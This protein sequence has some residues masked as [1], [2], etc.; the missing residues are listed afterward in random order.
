MWIMGQR[1]DEKR[2]DT[3]F[4]LTPQQMKDHWNIFLPAYIGTKDPQEIAAYTKRLIPFYATKV[5]YVYDMA[6]HGSLPETS[7]QIIEQMLGAAQ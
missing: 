3:L 1:M 4:H 7:F 5:P 2:A 6:Y